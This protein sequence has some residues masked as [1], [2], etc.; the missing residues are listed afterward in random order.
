MFKDLSM[1]VIIT[2]DWKKTI[3]KKWAENIFFFWV[4]VANTNSVLK[5]SRWIL[6]EH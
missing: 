3:C 6:L 1:E 5:N 4:F 2:K